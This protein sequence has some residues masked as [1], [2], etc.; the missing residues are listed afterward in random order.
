MKSFQHSYRTAYLLRKFSP[1]FSAQCGYAE[2]RLR[3]SRICTHGF[4]MLKY[5]Q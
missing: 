5:S 2:R 3:I 4:N 1:R